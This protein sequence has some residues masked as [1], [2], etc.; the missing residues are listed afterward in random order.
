MKESIIELGNNNQK[1]I[2]I[3]KNQIERLKQENYEGGHFLFSTQFLDRNKCED[4]FKYDLNVI[5][6]RLYNENIKCRNIRDIRDNLKTRNSIRL[7]NSSSSSSM[8]LRRIELYWNISNSNTGN[9]S[10]KHTTFNICIT[11]FLVE[12]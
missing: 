7:I 11:P 5:L 8:F 4:R 10:N 12:I 6:S 1:V 3:I 9:T 2:E